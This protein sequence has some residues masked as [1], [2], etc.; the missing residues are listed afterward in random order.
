MTIF[1]FWASAVDWPINVG[2]KPWNSWP[3][4]VPVIFEVTVLCGGV[5]TVLVLHLVGGT[6]AGTVSRRCPI[7][8]SPTIG[9]RWCSARRRPASTATPPR[10]CSPRFH[11]V[12][13]V[14]RDMTIRRRGNRHGRPRGARDGQDSHD[15]AGGAAGG[16]D[17]PEHRRAHAGRSRVRRSSTFPTWRAPRRYNAFEANPNFAD[18]MTLRVPPP[19]TIP[20]G[21]LPRVER[22]GHAGRRR[23]P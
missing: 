11:P 13:I 16:L 9:S 6:Q 17:R 15:R 8:A 5:G 2:G 4:F 20:R 22:A 12:S 21:L 23:R 10:R 3:A 1:Q 7:C 14:E 18:G 19:G